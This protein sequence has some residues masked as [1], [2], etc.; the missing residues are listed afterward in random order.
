MLTYPSFKVSSPTFIE[1]KMFPWSIGDEIATPAMSKFMSDYIHILPILG[2]EMKE[3]VIRLPDE[4]LEHS[5][6]PLKWC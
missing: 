4:F 6:V 2:D 3:N 5:G 1:P